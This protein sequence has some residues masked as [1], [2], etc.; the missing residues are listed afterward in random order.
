MSA[1]GTSRDPSIDPAATPE[2]TA[3]IV[4]AIDRFM[5]TSGPPVPQAT[6]RLDGWR[7]AAMLEGVSRA[8]TEDAPDPW[9]NT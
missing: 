8:E 6:E 4:A 2:E 5:R 1:N 7:R 3:A 9:I